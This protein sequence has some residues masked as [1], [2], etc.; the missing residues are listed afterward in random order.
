MTILVE[1]ERCHS[2]GNDHVTVERCVCDFCQ[3]VICEE[4]PRE[5]NLFGR[6]VARMQEFRAIH[7]EGARV[8]ITMLVFTTMDPSRPVVFHFCCESHRLEFLR[9][10]PE[11]LMATDRIQV[12]MTV[13]AITYSP[14]V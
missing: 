12:H 1:S 8:P 2:C 11:G 10:H 14:L 6:G 5:V 4:R 7:H 3:G 9:Q 13:D